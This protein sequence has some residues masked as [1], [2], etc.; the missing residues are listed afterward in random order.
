MT[1]YSNG[2]GNGNVVATPLVVKPLMVA[3]SDCKEFAISITKPAGS[4]LGLELD[5]MDR[6]RGYV[7]YVTPGGAAQLYNNSVT[8]AERKVMPGDWVVAAGGSSDPQTI[9]ENIRS[10]NPAEL[11]IRRTNP[12]NAALPVPDP[13]LASV[14]KVADNGKSLMINQIDGHLQKWNDSNPSKPIK[15]GDRVVEVNGI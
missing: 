6:T 12:F 2:N 8:D 9:V 3:T 13:S 14:F 5:F 10:S 4:N 15:I 1:V 11:V 7:S